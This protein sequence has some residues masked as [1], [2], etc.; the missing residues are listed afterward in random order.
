M[1]DKLKRLN[2]K[3]LYV[4]SLYL[5]FNQYNEIKSKIKGIRI[6]PTRG[7]VEKYRKRKTIE[8]IGKIRTAIRIAEK[9]Y[10]NLIKKIRVGVSEKNLSDILEYEIRKQGGERSS[11]EI[12]CATGSRASLPHAHTTDKKTQAK[13][14]ILIDW[15]ASFQFYNSDLT[16]ISFIDRISQKFKK[17]YRIVLDAQSYAIDS[18]KP[19]VLARDV[20]HAARSYIEKKGFGKYFGHGVGHGIGLEV[21]ENPFIN[22][23]SEEVLEEDMVFTV[24]PGIYVPG[25]GGIRIEDMLLV[26]YD[27]CDVLTNVP[28]NLT[29]IVV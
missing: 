14:V 1:C 29:E 4:E 26:T 13:D 18:I 6:I 21:H 23:R 12:I 9:A 20:D 28:K 7:V 10:L 19:G 24:E 22:K 3:R 27:G 11:F 16:R 15:G 2:I 5:T 17:I 25:V 8:E